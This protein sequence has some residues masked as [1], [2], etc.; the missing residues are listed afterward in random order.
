MDL[1]YLHLHFMFLIYI[2]HLSLIFIH[3]SLG[4]CEKLRYILLDVFL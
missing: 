2:E 1:I 3:G 4:L